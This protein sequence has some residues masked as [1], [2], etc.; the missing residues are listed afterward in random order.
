VSYNKGAAVLRMLRAWVNRADSTATGLQAVSDAPSAVSGEYDAK[1]A[2][3]SQQWVPH[4]RRRLQQQQQQQQKAGE[5]SRRR[6]GGVTSSV[7]ED[8]STST[9]SSVG[10]AGE[11][12]QARAPWTA[13]KYSRGPS[14]QASISPV[15]HTESGELSGLEVLPAGPAAPPAPKPAAA[16][17]KRQPS[18]A[19][20][21]SVG[22]R[23]GW[24][25]AAQQ[26]LQ[27]SPAARELDGGAGSAAGGD[28]FVA[29][30]GRYVKAHAYGNSG[31]KGLWSSIGEAAGEPVEEMMSVWTLRR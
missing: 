7:S 12:Q 11:G 14:I 24:L 27:E 1:L 2:S 29:G 17:T 28:A 20:A 6:K 25:A 19:A 8:S 9:S 3:T 15:L 4:L 10:G 26:R 5:G 30:L 13:H 31:Y 21:V 22:S 18:A 23:A 16:P